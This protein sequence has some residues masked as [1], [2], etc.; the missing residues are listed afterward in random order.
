[1]QFVIMPEIVIDTQTTGLDSLNGDRIV[2]IGAV[3]L[4]RVPQLATRFTTTCAG[5]APCRP[6]RSRCTG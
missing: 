2:E 4:I 3:E 6:T 5:N 1:V